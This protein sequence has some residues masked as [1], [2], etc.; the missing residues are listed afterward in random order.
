M[1]GWYSAAV[2]R[3]KIVSS[4]ATATLPQLTMAEFL[5]SGG[6]DHYLRRIRRTH[7]HNMAAMSRAIRSAFPQGSKVTQ[8][9][10][11]YLLWVELPDGADSLELYKLAL[12][13]NI[14]IAP[15]PIFSARRQYQNF[16]RLNAAS[17]SPAVEAAI[18]RL[19]RLIDQL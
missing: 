2:E 11:G 5:A 8:P 19:G 1:L 9:K 12:K 4:L 7:A 18:D 16:I 15:G 14:T 17:W 10:G 6:Y 13:S 3:L